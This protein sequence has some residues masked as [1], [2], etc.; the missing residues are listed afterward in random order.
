MASP[1]GDYD[2]AAVGRVSTVAPGYPAMRTQPGKAWLSTSLRADWPFSGVALLLRVLRGRY[3]ESASVVCASDPEQGLPQGGIESAVQ[4]VTPRRGAIVDPPASYLAAKDGPERSA[5]AADAKPEFVERES[6]RRLRFWSPAR[7]GILGA[8]P[9]LALPRSRDL[10]FPPVRVA[11]APT[12]VVRLGHC[13]I[14]TLPRDRQTDGQFAL[15][16]GGDLS[17]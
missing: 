10:G 12:R 8:P 5:I 11:G 1:S 4:D 2:A 16:R 7:R 15:H 9:A 17:R 3:P 14:L 13:P 6:A